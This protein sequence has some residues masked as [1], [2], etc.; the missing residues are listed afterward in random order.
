[1]AVRRASLVR[2]LVVQLK[3]RVAA[4][5]FVTQ[6]PSSTICQSSQGPEARALHTGRPLSSSSTTKLAEVGKLETVKE[7]GHY[8]TG[9]LF[10][11]KLFGYRGV[12]LFPWTARVYDRDQPTNKKEDLSNYFPSQGKAPNKE[13]KGKTENYYQ[14][15]PLQPL[16]VWL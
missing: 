12:I 1:M 13:V 7:E 16:G 14:V 15:S 11:H 3:P 8:N 6:L 5:G 2:L 9:Q 10:L 4:T